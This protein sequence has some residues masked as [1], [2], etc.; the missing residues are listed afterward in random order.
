MPSPSTAFVLAFALAAA[1]GS[2]PSPAARPSVPEPDPPPSTTEPVDE[3][4]A[5]PPA[6][7]DPAAAEPS[8][9]E[10][11]PEEPSP[12]EP[13]PD[14]PSPDED[15]PFG[16]HT[17]E[18]PWPE[19]VVDADEGEPDDAPLP[20][21][22]PLR[23]SPQALRARHWVRTGIGTMAAGGALLVGAIIVGASDPCARP[24]GNSCQVDARN[25]AALVMG[26]P[27]AILLGG[28]A[29]MLGI[30]LTRRQRLAID[31]QAGRTTVGITL[32]GR[33]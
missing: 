30:G 1:P 4:T 25:R 12:E 3:P 27:A 31:L 11:S 15:D 24:A 26:I 5:S 23:D 10:P 32:R 28:G 18:E 29:A 6:T 20:D 8:P 21:Y 13:S 9:E 16:D 33:F 22:D 7:D 14:E 19:E 17:D 2:A